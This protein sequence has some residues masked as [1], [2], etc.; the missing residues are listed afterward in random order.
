MT[1]THDFQVINVSEFKV[2]GNRVNATFYVVVAPLNWTEAQAIEFEGVLRERQPDLYCYA[3][4][5]D[6]SAGDGPIIAP[7]P[8]ERLSFR[9]IGDLP[10]PAPRVKV[11]AEFASRRQ[12]LLSMLSDRSGESGE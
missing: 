5:Y 11:E 8:V 12:A 9:W 2:R 10:G 3:L 4:R 7:I 6:E 1:K